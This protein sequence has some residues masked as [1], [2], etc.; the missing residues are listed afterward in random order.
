MNLRRFQATFV[1]YLRYW[2]KK[3]SDCLSFIEGGTY[4]ENEMDTTLP[5]HKDGQGF[6]R[7]GGVTGTTGKKQRIESSA[8][9]EVRRNGKNVGL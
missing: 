1:V 4:P 8:L 6:K 2:G 3:F 5:S 9:A 7:R